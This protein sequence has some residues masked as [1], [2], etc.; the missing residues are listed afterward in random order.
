MIVM[1]L[2]LSMDNHEFLVQSARVRPP[3]LDEF[4]KPLEEGPSLLKEDKVRAMVV[5]EVMGR[6]WEVRSC[7]G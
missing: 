4:L 1:V 3:L 6:E 5:M 2:N 7:L